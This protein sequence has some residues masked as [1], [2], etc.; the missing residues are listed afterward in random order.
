MR[1][2]RVARPEPVH[3]PEDPAVKTRAGSSHCNYGTISVCLH[4]FFAMT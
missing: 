3:G 2:V 4:K 1:E